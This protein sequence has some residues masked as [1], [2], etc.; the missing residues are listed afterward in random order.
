LEG[1]VDHRT[2]DQPGALRDEESDP[3]VAQVVGERVELRGGRTGDLRE[4]IQL[5]D[6]L[7]KAGGIDHAGDRGA[8]LT[9][10]N[11]SFPD[12]DLLHVAGEI[13]HRRR[14]VELLLGGS[15]QGHGE[16][17]PVHAHRGLSPADQHSGV[18]AAGARDAVGA[19]RQDLVAR[20][21]SL[22]VRAAF[23]YKT[24]PPAFKRDVDPRLVRRGG[25]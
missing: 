21:A 13:D 8:V 3:H 10:H 22:E 25:Q 15:R 16:S 1:E 18:E 23:H 12:L 9:V 17:L 6:R 5:R 2:A 11:A 7:Q 19:H 14:P 24:E 4:P 20:S